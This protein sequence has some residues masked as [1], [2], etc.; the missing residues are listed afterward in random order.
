VEELRSDDILMLLSRVQA[1]AGEMEERLD[2]ALQPSQLT[3]KRT[4][5]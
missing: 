2:A 4:R 1:E 5:D 3:A